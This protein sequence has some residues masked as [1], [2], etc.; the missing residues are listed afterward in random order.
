MGVSDS[1]YQGGIGRSPC[2]CAH[3]RRPGHREGD[4]LGATRRTGEVHAEKQG[5]MFW[6]GEPGHDSARSDGIDE[7]IGGVIDDVTDEVIGSA[8]SV[9][10][11]SPAISDSRVPSW[12][13]LPGPS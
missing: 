1:K 9:A 10:T 6:M 3:R 5:L 4:R 13:A 11:F 8:G 2:H 7:V 12:N